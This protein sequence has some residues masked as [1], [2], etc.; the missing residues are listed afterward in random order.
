MLIIGNVKL[1]VTVLRSRKATRYPNIRDSPNRERAIMKLHNLCAKKHTKTIKT[2]GCSTAM[3]AVIGVAAGCSSSGSVG[4][5]TSGSGSTVKVGLI[6]PLTGPISAGFTGSRDGAEARYKLANAA[7]GGRHKFELVVGD[8]QST[9]QGA[10]AAAQSLIA[11]GVVAI[12][13]ADPADVDGA[14]QSYISS[15]DIPIISPAMQTQAELKDPNN[16]SITGTSG[17]AAPPTD[18]VARLMESLGVQST[19]VV[20]WG[21]VAASVAL[22]KAPI[23]G[24]NAS[25]IKNVLQDL[26]STPTTTDFTSVALAVKKSGAQGVYTAMTI[27]PQAS[28][29]QALKQQSVPLKAF[30]NYPVAFESSA[31]SGPDAAAF[32][33]TYFLASSAPQSVHSAGTELY[34]QGG[35]ADGLLE[36]SAFIEA[37]LVVQ[38]ADSVKGNVTS[39]SLTGAIRGITSYDADGLL[40]QKLNF[41]PSART[42]TQNVLRCNW[43]VK[44]ANG[45]FNV[46]SNKPVCGSI[47]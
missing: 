10:L 32:D 46:L 37:D 14:A 16:Y 23:P 26:S 21:D 36:K 43:Y 25:G 44:I 24:F 34:A 13:I 8:D 31:L 18:S 1:T 4:G 40:S 29:V 35:A 12:Q 7:S 27:A 9:S 20:G 30:L 19:A 6:L 22:V 2:L 28:L 11:Q 5:S 38:A 39:S 33:G 45:K 47:V 3:L 15:H 42:S 41:S 17:D